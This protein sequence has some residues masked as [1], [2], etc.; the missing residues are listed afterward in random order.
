M[1]RKAANSLYKATEIV[2]MKSNDDKLIGYL[3]AKLE[4]MHEDIRQLQDQVK[5]LEKDLH[6]RKGAMSALIWMS[7]LV[8]S[9][10]G[11]AIN[12]FIRTIS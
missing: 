8:G 12:Y 11:F 5:Q 2:D 9:A 10:L 7:G 1:A 3:E 6:H 4:G